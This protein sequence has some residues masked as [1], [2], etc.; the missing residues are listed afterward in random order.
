MKLKSDRDIAF[1]RRS[2]DLV[3]RTLG[4]VAH[5]VDVGVTLHELD[6]VADAFI[7]EAGARPAFRGYD[8][9]WGGGAFP[10]SVC[11]SV[12]DVV[13]HGFPTDYALRNGDIVTIDIGVQLDG[14][15]GDSGYTFK[16]G[17]VSDE[18]QDL[19]YHT[20][21]SLE[22]GVDQ[23]R[24]GQRVGAIGHAVQTYCEGKGFGV[25]RDLVGH[26]IGKQLH[27]S[28]QVPNFGKPKEGAKMKRGLSICIEPMIGLRSGETT[29]DD[30][31]WT[32]RTLDRLPAAHYEHMVVV[33]KDEPLVLTT[34]DYIHDVRPAA[35]VRET[36]EELV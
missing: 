24:H 32:V 3:S 4:E 30:D 7:R 22:I 33:Q 35:Y 17:D 2:A 8:P 26:G 36:R 29:T 12:N 34:F 21:R 27:E 6:E 28:P 18:V 23:A 14:Y 31:K 15:Y 11:A 1:L 25:V 16:V 20:H 10:G 13:V 19:L 9:G 5:Y